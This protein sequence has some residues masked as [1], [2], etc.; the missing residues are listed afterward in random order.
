MKITVAHFE[1]LFQHLPGRCEKTD[2]KSQEQNF[3]V[4]TSEYEAGMVIH[5][6]STFS[7]NNC[8][9]QTVMYW[10]SVA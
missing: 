8:N 1:V 7:I 6:D 3:E 5:S 10:F 4:G 2:E 9:R